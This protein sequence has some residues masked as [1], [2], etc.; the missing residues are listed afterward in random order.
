MQSPSPARTRRVTRC[1]GAGVRV[2][3]AH[4]ARAKLG[5]LRLEVVESSKVLLLGVGACETARGCAVKFRI[6]IRIGI[7]IGVRVGIR[8]G[9]GGRVRVRVRMRIGS[10]WSSVNDGSVI[11]PHPSP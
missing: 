2:A 8:D 5:V 1:P 7:R 9:V 6:G 10:E 3:M 4:G 11:K